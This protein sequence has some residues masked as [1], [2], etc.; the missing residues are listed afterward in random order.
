MSEG[1][2]QLEP[3]RPGA[4][5]PWDRAAAAHLLRRGGF[6][7]APGDVQRA[8]AEGPERTRARLF[9]PPGHEPALLE[10][11]RHMLAAGSVEHLQAWWMALILAGGDPLRERVTLMWH[12]HFA[13]SHDKV[14]DVRLMHRQNELFRALGLGDFRVLLHALAKDP[15][16]L[17]W[18]DGDQNRR[19]HPNENF[20][21]EV[22]ELFGLG[23]GH[24]A[25]HDVTEAARAF[26][27]WG[28]R[29]RAFAYRAE[30]HDAGEKT[31]FGR[32]G[33]FTGE[34]VIDLVL[35][36]PAC[37]RWIA[38]RLLEEF[39]TPDATDALVDEVADLLVE[40]DWNVGQTLEQLL[41]SRLFFAAEHRSA[42]I[43]G[44]VELVAFSARATGAQ[45][46]PKEVARAAGRMGQSLFRPPSV[47]GWDG[48]RAWINAGTWLARHNLLTRLASAHVDGGE[49]LRVDLTVCT[50]QPRSVDE[51]PERVCAALLFA[52]HGDDYERVLHGAAAEANDVDGA[53]ARVAALVMTSPEYHLT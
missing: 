36:H 32:R 10:G 21:R 46:P 51:V 52:P 2:T 4:D 43:A 8:V 24:Y 49:K 30:H 25:E 41:G 40:H 17:V 20:A 38:R 19:G 50:D 9:E 16:M 33:D 22:L 45:V 44:P 28:T 53:L 34:E 35:A 5:G 31:V 6:G 37:P 23:I 48:G 15:A 26:T 47:K 3:F 14:D 39:V 42:R 1:R 18:L 29:G 11:I 27:G 13:T 12:D 7:P